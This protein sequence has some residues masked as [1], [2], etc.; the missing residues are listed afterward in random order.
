MASELGRQILH[1][2]I[3]IIIILSL[4]FVEKQIVLIVLFIIFLLSVLLS[5]LSLKIKVPAIS[6]LLR[7]FEKNIR[8][9]KLPAKGFIFF[10]AGTLLTI[11]LF[12][13]NIAL[14]A[15]AVL[16][17][18]DS[19]ST[20]MGHH[21]QKYNTKPFNKLKSFCG[22]LCGFIISFLIALFFITPIFA[23]VAAAFGMLVEAISIKLGEEADDNLVV[24]LA[25]GTACY[26][27][28]FVL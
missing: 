22:T 10:I 12:P 23:F 25:A 3:G 24:P 16:I 4:L 17:F 9:S 15:L 28:M 21:G 14:A 18:G 7:N 26:I 20:I 19:I 1:I 8:K 11:K 2:I 5:L 6:F 13:Q 27:L